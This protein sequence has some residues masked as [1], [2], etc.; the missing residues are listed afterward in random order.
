MDEDCCI[1]YDTEFF[2]IDED[3][4]AKHRYEV[5]VD[6]S[7]YNERL[8]NAESLLSGHPFNDS[9]LSVRCG[10]MTGATLCV[11]TYTKDSAKDANGY[12]TYKCNDE[13]FAKDVARG[14]SYDTLV[15]GNVISSVIIRPIDPP[16]C[17]DF[18]MTVYDEPY[19]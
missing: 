19:C 7:F 13:A 3:D 16:K 18:E 14:E 2:M 9:I 1:F 11:G 17:P 10:N 6:V 8:E 5:C 4:I 12:D 15:S